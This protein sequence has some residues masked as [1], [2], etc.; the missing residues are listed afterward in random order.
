MVFDQT[1][2]SPMLIDLVRI[3]R[4]NWKYYEK[5]KKNDIVVWVSS[6]ISAIYFI[7]FGII[8]FYPQL[9]MYN[10]DEFSKNIEL[11]K[12]EYSISNNIC[13]DNKIAIARCLIPKESSITVPEPKFLVSMNMLCN[14]VVMNYDSIK[15]YKC[16]PH[17]TIQ[18]PFIDQDR[19]TQT[20][21]YRENIFKYLAGQINFLT[22]NIQKSF[23]L[24]FNQKKFLTAAK[25]YLRCI[26][27]LEYI[28]MLNVKRPAPIDALDF[29]GF[30][31]PLST[32]DYTS[33]GKIDILNFYIKFYNKLCSI[34]MMN[35]ADKRKREK[36]RIYWEGHTLL[37]NSKKV[38]KTLENFNAKVVSGSFM[39]PDLINP[40]I[41]EKRLPYPLTQENLE[42][43][44][45]EN[46]IL[47]NRF[48]I[49]NLDEISSNEMMAR[50]LFNLNYFKRGREFRQKVTAEFIKRYDIDAVI[51][52]S[53]HNCRFWSLPQMQLK[54]FIT[55]ELNMPCLYLESD[56]IDEQV[57]SE[58]QLMN[59]LESFLE[60]II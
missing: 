37:Q 57:I 58:A 30:F 60:G 44:I 25:I 17:Y 39:I 54:D 42:G 47:E 55:N 36:I 40:S 43:F 24:K 7:S 45:K 59:R 52:L 4:S 1:V 29:I 51:I 16:I 48:Y 23:N 2:R 46:K 41:W 56:P 3:L 9:F 6:G 19:L 53:A 11:I 34:A 35:I 33:A 32:S 5:C 31:Q 13:S 20:S 38:K 15:R 50:I 18:I 14:Q 22:N 27:I 49:K 28:Q 10:I 26:I 12:N 21:T 8:P